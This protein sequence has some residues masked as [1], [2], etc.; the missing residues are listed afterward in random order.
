MREDKQTHSIPKDLSK[1]HDVAILL[2]EQN[3]EKFLDHVSEILQSVHK[4][5]GELSFQLPSHL[6]YNHEQIQKKI[7]NNTFSDFIG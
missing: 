7:H 1:L 6:T 5:V 3:I 2:G 4:I